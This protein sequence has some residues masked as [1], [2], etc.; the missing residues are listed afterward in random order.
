MKTQKNSLW[1]T[2]ISSVFQA[3]GHKKQAEDRAWLALKMDPKN[4]RAST[5]L[6]GLVEPRDGLTIL[7]P[8][9]QTLESS[10]HW[11][12]S[13]LE[14][15]GLAKM[16]FILAELSWHEEHVDAATGFWTRA[17]EVDFTDYGRVIKC[18][19]CYATQEQWCEI[20]AILRK[21]DYLST[22]NLPGLSEPIAAGGARAF[23][24]RT[25][26]Q[27]A[28]HLDELEFVVSAYEHS[29]QLAE[30]RRER[31]AL[32]HLRHHCGR[33][34]HAL[35]NGSSKA[36]KHWRRALD[37]ADPY[38]MSTLISSIAPYYLQKADASAS[39]PES[40]STYLTEIETLLPED[41]PEADV[42]FP[43]KVYIAQ[44]YWRQ[45]NKVQAKQIARDIVQ[46]SL[47]ILSDDDEGNDRPAYNQLL[48]VF[49][50]FGDMTNALA[51]RA[52]IVLNFGDRE[53]IA[54]DGEC[55]RSWPISDETQWCQD[56][57]EAHF[58]EECGR[59]IQQNALPF[60]V[61]NNTHQFLRAPR[62]DESLQLLSPRK[63]PLGDEVISFEDWLSRIKMDYVGLEI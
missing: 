26:L 51:T 4:W 14:R 5:L 8:V 13:S 34:T 61:C 47:D 54:C 19:G 18:L 39:D 9:A 25:I 40:V 17:V 31:A 23:P 28:L 44:Y 22:E 46:L 32:C 24:H 3:Y 52:L 20:I 7:K 56:C 63:V 11:K 55:N 38:L 33:A 53:V 48:S 59:K 62:M 50:A 41:V 10:E 36:V 27:A 2:Q 16:L 21:I 43:P 37:G 58:E 29:V 1:H 15:V 57:I 12:T 30:K 45:G 35:Q 49:I 42:I 6:A 60:S